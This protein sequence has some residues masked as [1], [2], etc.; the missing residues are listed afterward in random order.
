MAWTKIIA[1]AHPFQSLTSVQP[2]QRSNSTW[3]DTKFYFGYTTPKPTNKFWTETLSLSPCFSASF[4]VS[5][6]PSLENGIYIMYYSC[7]RKSTC[8]ILS[9]LHRHNAMIW[10]AV[11]Y[12]FIWIQYWFNSFAIRN[13]FILFGC[14]AQIRQ[15]R[16][17]PSQRTER[18]C[19]SIKNRTI[20][21]FHSIETLSTIYNLLKILK[22][23]W[24]RWWWYDYGWG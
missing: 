7:L 6:W 15:H 2:R 13:S 19:S 1:K 16:S 14:Q 22:D 11:A 5:Q 20:T 12:R 24:R 8:A 4:R 18:S 21:N 17:K 10:Q 23:G 9:I 3:L